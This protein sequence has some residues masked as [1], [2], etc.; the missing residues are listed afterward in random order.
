MLPRPGAWHRLEQRRAQATP[1]R[2]AAGGRAGLAAGCGLGGG[3]GA[4]ACTAGARAGRSRSTS[5]AAP[6]S[7]A[8]TSAARPTRARRSSSPT[9]RGSISRRGRGCRWWL[10]DRTA[11]GCASRRGGALRGHAPAARRLERRGGPLRRRGDGDRVRRPLVERGRGRR[12]SPAVGVG[13]GERAD[14]HRA[15]DAAPGPAPDGA[16]GDARA[17]HRRERRH[18]GGSHPLRADRRRSLSAAGR[19]NVA[20]RDGAA[21]GRRAARAPTPGEPRPSAEAPPPAGAAPVAPPSP[22][23][24][25]EEAGPRGGLR[26][27]ARPCPSGRPGAGRSACRPATPRGW[28][29][30]RWRTGST[31]PSPRPTAAELVALADAAR[32]AGRTYLAERVLRAQRT[33]FP[34]TPAAGAAA[35]FLGRLADDRGRRGGRA[36]LVPALPDR[37][38]PGRLRRRGARARD[39]RRGPPLRAT[40]GARAG[41]RVSQPLPGRHLPAA[42]PG[43]SSIPVIAGDRSVI[44]LVLAGAGALWIGLL[45]AAAGEPATPTLPAADARRSGAGRQRDR[46]GAATAAAAKPC[47]R[48]RARESAPS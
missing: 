19:G 22:R 3:G 24:R 15:R 18:R 38:A 30:R 10:R 36:R 17:A 1:P 39:D 44:V 25:R 40:G 37:G 41:A 8:A 46:G 16:P 7:R 20:R 23:A 11:R 6:S 48:R 42:R 4:R 28:S 47:S 12:G 21:T 26:R 45:M 31:P 27:I 13:A 34:G 43:Y 9:A 33:R 35:F 2:S 32:Y 5:A 29:P 14:A